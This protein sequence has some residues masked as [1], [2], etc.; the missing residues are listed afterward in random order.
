MTL[1]CFFK[2]SRLV[3]RLYTQHKLNERGIEAMALCSA[4]PFAVVAME[5]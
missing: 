2:E 1:A 5:T 4:R 3:T